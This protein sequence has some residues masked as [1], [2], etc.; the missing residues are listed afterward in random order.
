MRSADSCRGATSTCDAMA[1]ST[2]AVL[3]KTGAP[4]LTLVQAH[5]HGH[6]SLVDVGGVARGQVPGRPDGEH[7][8]RA[9]KGPDGERVDAVGQRHLAVELAR[10]VAVR[11]L[12]RDEDHAVPRL[13]RQVV[14]P[15]VEADVEGNLRCD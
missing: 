4:W 6:V 7:S 14:R 9:E 13:H 15:E 2:F 12:G 8:R 5:A 10:D 11:A 3:D 1:G